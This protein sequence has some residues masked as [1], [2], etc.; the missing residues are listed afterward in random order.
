LS[1]LNIILKHTFNPVVPEMYEAAEHLCK[2]NDVIIGHGMLYPAQTAAEKAGKPYA[3]VTPNHLNVSSRHTGPLGLLK[4][5]KWHNP[6][7]WKVAGF[8]I[9]ITI[10]RDVNR[11]RKK[12]GLPQVKNIMNTVMTSHRLNLV[13]ESAAIGLRQADWPDYQQVCGVLSVPD[14]AEDWLMPA[15]LKLFIESGPRPVFITLGSMISLETSPSAITSLLV[16][17]ALLAGC[18]AI[19]Q[20]RWDEIQDIPGHQDIYKIKFVPHQHVFPFCAAVVHHGGAGSSHSATL[21]GCPSIVIEHFFDQVFFA[22]E[23]E[24]LGV[25]PKA[26]HRRNVTAKKLAAAIR[27]VLDSPDMKRRAEALGAFMQKERGVQRA[28]ELIE[29]R[30][31][32]P[33]H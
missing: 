24:S 26:L 14:A 19:V 31:G 28:V 30:F 9:D 3:T 27:T 7:A 4:L 25:A 21:H 11:L 1:Q 15:D 2:E 20:S 17:A 22:H 5:G 32:A 18:R 8:L 6:F 33:G 13:A 12:V 16:Q 23:L 29:S 10:G